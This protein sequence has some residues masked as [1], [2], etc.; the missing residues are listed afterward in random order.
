VVCRVSQTHTISISTPTLAR[1][2]LQELAVIKSVQG[3]PRA[4]NERDVL[5]RFQHRTPCLRPLIDEIEK[6]S[7]PVT[8][9]LKHLQADLLHASVART[10]DRREFKYVSR[11]VLEALKTLHEDG[12]VYAGIKLFSTS[13]I[14]CVNNGIPRCQAR[15]SLRATVEHSDWYMGFWCY[16]ASDLYYNYEDR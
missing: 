3:H 15:D 9:A 4:Q 1:N 2:H 16:G 11:C 10:L 7:A 14:M 12:F 5:R 6:P 8:I 13:D